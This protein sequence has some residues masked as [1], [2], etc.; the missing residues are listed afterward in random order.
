MN[1]ELIGGLDI[2][3]EMRS[4]PGMLKAELNLTAVEDAPVV[5]IRPLEERLRN[6]VGLKRV[7]VFI[8]GTPDAPR[9]GFSS[10]IVAIL[11]EEGFDFGYFDILEDE[12]VRQGLKAYSKWPTY[13]Q[14]YVNSELIGGLDIIEELRLAGELSALK[15]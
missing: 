11:Q 6:L 3:K 15:A 7:M 9:C 13:P 14:V 2:V 8:K 1:S 5:A 10:K 12:E 4:A